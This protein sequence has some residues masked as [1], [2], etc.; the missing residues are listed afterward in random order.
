M[1]FAKGGLLA[2]FWALFSSISG[3]HQIAD[4]AKFLAER[5]DQDQLAKPSNC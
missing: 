5:F 4:L 2:S 3:T 1:A